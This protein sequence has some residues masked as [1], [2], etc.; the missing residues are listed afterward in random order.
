VEKV[1]NKSPNELNKALP[2]KR[3]GFI[4]RGIAYVVTAPTGDGFRVAAMEVFC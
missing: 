2:D 3:T 1:Q 4:C